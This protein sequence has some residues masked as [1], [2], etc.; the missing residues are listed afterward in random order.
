MINENM[1][2]ENMINENMINEN[3]INENMINSFVKKYQ[4]SLDFM[5]IYLYDIN[6]YFKVTIYGISLGIIS[7]VFIYIIVPIF[8]ALMIMFFGSII[9]EI[10]NI[11]KNF[12]TLIK[13]LITYC[14]QNYK[15]VFDTIVFILTINIIFQIFYHFLIEH[16]CYNI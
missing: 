14:R 11:I 5:N 4:C 7:F 9:Y 1:I 12:K 13:N 6:Y 2:N 3:M 8:G 15:L 16:P 10:S